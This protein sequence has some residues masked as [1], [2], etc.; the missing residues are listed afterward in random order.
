ME[1][2][3][4]CETY[5]TNWQTERHFVKHGFVIPLDG[6]SL[7]C[8]AELHFYPISTKDK[9]RLHQFGTKIIP[10]TFMDKLRALE[11]VGRET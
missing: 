9:S 6:Q 11:E 10:G 8:G 7:P 5:K 4:F 2:F 3:F 1:C